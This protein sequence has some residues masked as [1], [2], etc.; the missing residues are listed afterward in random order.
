MDVV[1]RLE[2]PSASQIAA[3]LPSPPSYS[4]VRALLAILVTKGHLRTEAHGNRYLYLPAVP[5]KT[6]GRKAM[7]DVV[8]NFFDGSPK[9]AVVALLDD[10]TR[11]LS[12]ADL[13]ELRQR[14]DQAK[15][16]GK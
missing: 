16:R 3:Q 15:Q 1:Y 8:A 11:S 13:D 5:R 10:T 9:Q 6:A 4:A 2:N 14:I 7:R 12:A